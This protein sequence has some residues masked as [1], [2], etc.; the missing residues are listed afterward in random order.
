ME[1]SL[2]SL[3][4]G[5]VLQSFQLDQMGMTADEAEERSFKNLEKDTPHKLTCGNIKEYVHDTSGA[6]FQGTDLRKHINRWRLKG[7]ANSEVLVVAFQDCCDAIRMY[8]PR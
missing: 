5:Y 1:Q 8:V 4:G 6:M 3:S 7:T 2:A